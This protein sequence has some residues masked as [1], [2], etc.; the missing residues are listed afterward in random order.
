MD[1][2]YVFISYAHKDSDK[3]LSILSAMQSRGLNLWYDEGIEAGTEWPEYIG[4]RLKG[5]SVVIAFMSP[6]AAASVNCRNEIN[7]A[8][9]LGKDMLVV[10][11]E[12]TK[13]SAG[14]QLQLGSI[15]AMFYERSGSQEE[16]INNLMRAEILKN[17]N[18]AVKSRSAIVIPTSGKKEIKK[19]TNSS[20]LI[21]HVRSVSS[22]IENDKEPAGEYSTVMSIKNLK[23]IAFHVYFQNKFAKEKEIELFV[24]ITDPTGR[25]VLNTRY[26]CNVKTK[27]ESMA[28]T[29]KVGAYHG[30]LLNEGDYKAEFVLEDSG[31]YTYNFR[32]TSDKVKESPKAVIGR[33]LASIEDSFGIPRY[34]LSYALWIG[35][36]ALILVGANLGLS[37]IWPGWW[38]F[39]TT[40]ATEWFKK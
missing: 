36:I 40:P 17:M 26:T 8:L 20:S 25:V 21:A 33:K 13:L 37:K 9:S 3:V 29:W 7:Y 1:K 11:L 22:T 31:V 30:C 6:Y 27:T 34:S 18:G 19:D 16:F 14:M 12:D 4:E 2:N 35:F 24:K 38:N 10:Y 32:I 15:Q 39:L 5:A 23:T 28:I